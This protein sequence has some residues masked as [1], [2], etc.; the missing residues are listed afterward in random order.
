M[1][2][3]KKV[4]EYNM[5]VLVFF[6]L[7]VLFMLMF[8]MLTIRD[9]SIVDNSRLVNN[10]DFVAKNTS[11]YDK[12]EIELMDELNSIYAIEHKDVKRCHL[13]SDSERKEICLNFFK[14]CDK[15][16]YLC[17]KGRAVS[18]RNDS[19]C[20]LIDDQTI[21]DECLLSVDFLNKSDL[22]V[23]NMDSAYCDK[24]KDVV[25]K[26]L[27]HDNFNLNLRFEN[28]DLSY[29]KNIVNEGILRECYK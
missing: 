3:R 21:K 15:T 6:I 16:D 17:L 9:I 23:K 14:D 1:T 26:G 8:F 2:N 29:C 25:F 7:F 11:E 22:A 10:A 19:Y 5:H 20:Y 18:Y 13:I 24:I 4:E 12:E 28:N 27:C